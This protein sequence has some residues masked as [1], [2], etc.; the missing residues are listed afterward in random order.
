[1]TGLGGG[2]DEPDF[3]GA[4]KAGRSKRGNGA[5]TVNGEDETNGEQRTCPPAEGREAVFSRDP[6]WRRRL[7]RI[8]KGGIRACLA[9]ALIALRYAPEWEDRFWFDAFHNRAVLRGTPPWTAKTFRDEPWSDLLDNLT[10]NWLQHQG[11]IVNKEITGAA[12]WTAAHDQWFHPARQYLA[13]CRKAWDGTKRIENWTTTYLGTPDTPYARAVGSCWLVSLVARVMEPGCKADCALV[14]EGP[15]GLFKSEVLRNL[16]APWVTDDM[17]GSEPGQ[18]DAAIQVAGIWIFELAE[19]DQFTTGRDVSRTK[20]FMSR[21]TDRFR[22][23]YGRHAV[24]QPRQCCFGCTTNKEEYLPDETGNRRWW[25]VTC[26]EINLPLLIANRD[27]LFGEAVALYEKGEPWW[28]DTPDLVALATTEQDKRYLPDAWDN[29]IEAYVDGP[30]ETRWDPSTRQNV[31]RTLP[32][33]DS[34]TVAE[35]LEKVLNLEPG[36]WGQ[37]EQNRVARS[38]RKLGWTRKQKQ[39]SNEREWRYWRPER[40]TAPV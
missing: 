4:K 22:P 19:L 23:P 28:L 5:Q 39:V 14:L 30:I 37:S 16:G 2:W 1:M 27:Q 31:T 32:S 33:L 12:V 18:K 25:P 38:M 35:I 9:N 3:D 10:T 13:K 24:P 34:V 20:S 21:M 29:L 8:S 6:N 11:I 26:I 36:H 17:G 40:T 15:Q 7:L